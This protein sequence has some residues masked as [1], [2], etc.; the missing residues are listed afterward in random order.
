VSDAIGQFC[1]T[2]RKQKDAQHLVVS[3]VVTPDDARVLADRDLLQTLLRAL[4]HDFLTA[5]SLRINARAENSFV[6]FSLSFAGIEADDAQLDNLF[7]AGYATPHC[8]IA[9]QIV[10]EHD[11]ACGH[12]GL[13]LVAENTERGYRILFSLPAAD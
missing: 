8:L 7:T 11:A 13:R 10:R 5:T 4:A 1:D 2:L 6:V 12:P 3:Q 9:R